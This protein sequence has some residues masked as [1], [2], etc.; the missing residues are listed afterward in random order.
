MLAAIERLSGD[1]LSKLT[2]EDVRMI[3]AGD[4]KLAEARRGMSP[5]EANPE[6][7]Q[8]AED[9]LDNVQGV[10]QKTVD[11]IRAGVAH[12]HGLS[13]L[14]FMRN[15]GAALRE[16]FP[17]I[18]S[19]SM[20]ELVK[21]HP[22]A[23]RALENATQEEVE[24]VIRAMGQ[25]NPK[26]VEDIL[27]SYMYKAQ[28]KARKAGG[29]LEPPSNVG[30]R[31]EESVGNLAEARARGYPFGFK[32]KSQYEQFM[33][34]LQSEISARKINGTPKVQGSAMHSKTPGDIDVEVLV[35]QAEFD[36]LSKKFLKDAPESAKKQVQ[37]SIGKQKIPSYQFFPEYKP[38]VADAVKSLT[39]V[40]GPMEV[41]ATLIVKGSEFD[42]GPFL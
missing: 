6:L 7:M 12:Q 33:T 36:R 30:A 1:D 38:S 5:G 14:P 32:D 24:R 34:K 13:D 11:E 26:D 16:R 2:D 9:L 23:L 42:L 8:T 28:K 22:D 35:E 40:D 25:G 15:P 10:G 41:Q 37:I 21:R 27:R 17:S 39:G 20:D 18:P 4:S 29:A 19:V 31:V 3:A